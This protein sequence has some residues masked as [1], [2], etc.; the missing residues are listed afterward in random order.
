MT[1]TRIRIRTRKLPP[2][3]VSGQFRPTLGYAWRED[4]RIDVDPR[5]APQERLDTI[6]HEAL[7]LLFPKLTERKTTYRAV[8]LSNLLWRQGYRRVKKRVVKTSRQT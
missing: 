6:I 5:Q 3:M 1:L 8:Q 7:H 2:S 4:W